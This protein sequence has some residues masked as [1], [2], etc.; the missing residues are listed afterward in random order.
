MYRHSSV[1]LG[2]VALS[3]LLA[4]LLAACGDATPTSPA[5]QTSAPA[6]STT[7]TSLPNGVASQEVSFNFG[8]GWVA[9][10]QFV[11]PAGK[12]GPFPIVILIP[13][14]GPN[15]M[16][17]T[18]PEQAAGIPG[19]SAMFRDI[20]YHLAQQGFATVRY[21]KRGI[22]ELGPVPSLEVRFTSPAKPFTQYIQDATFVLERTLEN[23][24]VDPR[25]VLMLGISEGSIV[26]SQVATSPA[27]KDV[28]GLVLLGSVGYDIKQTLQ[29]QLVDR[30]IAALTALIEPGK[31]KE[32]KIS[33]SQFTGWLAQLPA[34][35]KE[36]FKQKYLAADGSKFNPA[37]DKN[38]DGLLDLTG[39]VKPFLMEATG[40]NNFPKVNL[41]PDT[42]NL[43]TDLYQYGSV[44]SLL[45]AY[46]RPVLLLHGEND[47]ATVVQGVRETEA[48][49]A[50]AKHP[51]YKLIV[52]PGLGHTLYP[53]TAT[54]QPLGSPTAEVMKDLDTW[55]AARFTPKS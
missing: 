44:T 30:E 42:V 33:L 26:S 47:N 38:G 3:F 45:A 21:H 16:N 46:K 41:P 52:Y 50:K 37:V 19:G 55:L 11:Y 2:S 8:D 12:A 9:K 5:A 35:F 7:S 39:E 1:I 23:K 54:A 25:R 49:L 51:D 43:V 29:F 53:A 48:A 17:H 22:V 4:I 15:D 24:L 10:G 6:T 36:G 32:A 14:S 13:G 34:D 18:I 31:E 40:M 27:G 28:A 20:A